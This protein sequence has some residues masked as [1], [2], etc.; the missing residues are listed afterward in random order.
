M[1]RIGTIFITDI[2]GIVTN[3]AAAIIVLGLV[4][5]PSLYAWFNIAASWDPY[6]Q[7]G[8]L[9]VAVVND[10]R[11]ADL[12]GNRQNFGDEIVASLKENKAIGWAF[13]DD[14][15]ALKGVQHGDYYASITIPANFSERIVTV[16]TDNPQKAEIEYTV[17]EK[18]NAVAPKITGKGASGIIEEVSR[19]FVKTANGAIF[20]LFNEIGIELEQNL[21]SI[22]RVRD[23]IFRL[24]ALIPEIHQAMDVAAKDVAK[25]QAI[26]NTVQRDL[27]AVEQLARDGADFADRLGQFL[28]RSG[29]ALAAIEPGAKQDLILLQQIANSAAELTAILQAAKPDPA[30]VAEALE[31]TAG[32][33]AI[34]A[35][36]ADKFGSALERLNSFTGSS[37]LLAPFASRVQQIEDRFNR[38]LTIVNRIRDAVNRGA[39]PSAELVDELNRLAADTSTAIGS[40]LDRY[41]TE[42]KPRLT[43]AIDRAKQEAAKAQTV[44]SDAVASIPDMNLIVGDAIKGL[45]AGSKELAAMQ[46]DWPAAENRLKAL[47]DRIRQL[48]REGNLNELIDLLKNNT[49]QESDFFAEPV[50]L[51]E[52]KLFPIPNYGSAM[53]P[54][55]TTLSL[56][57]GALLLVSL[58]AVEVHEEAVVYRSYQVY[59]GRFLTFLTTALLQSG[60]VTCGDIWLL[61]TYVVNKWA[62]IVFGLLLSAVFMLMVYTLVSVFGNVGKAMAIVLLVLQLAGSGG[63]FPIEVTPRFFQAIHPFLPFTYGISMMREAAGGIVWD[64]VTRDMTMLA[65]FATGTLVVGLALKKA[66]NR[67]TSGFIRKAKASRLIH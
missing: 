56:W 5:L 18:I 22:L 7:T 44:L 15:Q 8:G 63:T 12:R 27:P 66:I 55:F 29:E 50:L 25:A 58:L 49:A 62:F 6:G 30:I 59:F 4:G 31:R 17:N 21:P 1:K 13:T 43:Q 11:G 46:H 28:D 38:Q 48:E 26:A 16:L 20:G 53:S 61:G 37:Q 41:D 47:A 52:N 64:I 19:N 33:L 40:L 65:L 57:V 35:D 42:L 51:K 32:R 45:A 3:W 39:A 24:E 67:G 23:T 60:L 34:A 2:R 54:F 9:R 14:R 10:D 36:V